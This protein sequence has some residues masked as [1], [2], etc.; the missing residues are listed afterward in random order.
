[1]SIVALTVVIV[2]MLTSLAVAA[3]SW[4]AMAGEGDLPHSHAGFGGLQFDD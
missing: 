2:T 4:H 1:M 3:V